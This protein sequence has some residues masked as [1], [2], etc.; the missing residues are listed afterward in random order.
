MDDATRDGMEGALKG[1]AAVWKHILSKRALIAV[2]S[3]TLLTVLTLLRAADPEFLASVRELTFDSYQRLAPRDYGDPPVRIVD[4]D[5]ETLNA[6]G[7]WPWPRTRL[8][9]MTRIL[10]E[11]GAAAIAFDVI[12]SEPDRSSP[13]NIAK[14][15][16]F[17]NKVHEEFIIGTLSSLADNDAAFAEA[18]AE[19]PVVLGFATVGK[20][21]GR[22]PQP[23]ASFAHAGTDPVTFLKPEP[24]LLPALDMLEARASGTGSVSLSSADTRGIVRRIPLILSDGE[25]LYPSLA[26]ETLRVAQGASSIIVRSTGASGQVDSG[27]D[28]VTAVKIGAYEVPTT[29]DGEFWVRYDTDRPERYLSARHLFDPALR[30]QVR[31]WVEGQIVLV[32]TSAVGLL[33][34]RATALGQ[35]VPG[36][37]I[38]AQALEQILQEVYISRPDW[39]DGA[40]TLVTFVVGSL[41]IFAFPALG[42]IGTALLGA[43]IATLLMGGSALLFF[44]E[45]LLIDPV[46]PNIAAFLVFATA[47]AILYVITEREKRFVRQAFGQYLSPHLV[48]QLESSPEQLVLGGDLR[49]MTILFMDVRGFTPI[50]EQLTPQELVSFLNTLLSPLSD[51]I[52]SKDG[53][54]DK[55]I[56]DSIMAFWNAPLLQT[57]HPRL[58]CRAGLAMLERLDALNRDDGF[59]FRARGFKVQSVQIGIGI[60]TGEACVGNMG[61]DQRFNYSVIGDA[62]NVASRIE[63]SCKEAGA[64]LLVSAATRDAVPDFAYLEAREI[65]LKGK[66]EPVRL[67]ALIGDETLAAQP[68]FQELSHTHQAMIDAWREGRAEDAR[69][70][71]D[72]C[73]TLAPERLTGF[74]GQFARAFATTDVDRSPALA[75]LA[76][77]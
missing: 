10:N 47:T 39:A 5:E 41:V 45:G 46:Y 52:L 63:S 44:E 53:T 60:N 25:R 51:V 17:E 69:A 32:G 2:T 48:N 72:T 58:A 50:S 71:L 24:A 30:D 36:V 67:F 26:A 19:A 18:I 13:P 8:A 38:H 57:D 59:G 76:E 11:L 9:E 3:V 12:F 49:D 75:P 43:A 33:D 64:D 28:A 14:T 40:E 77:T 29:A 61:S 15:I 23:K 56:G 7:Q 42:S 68:P 1:M 31:P 73:R 34:I 35:V 74:Y 21:T 54:I 62:V 6:F 27:A 70:H 37:S 22:A 16:Q 20:A 66:S 65:P 4:I 55:Y